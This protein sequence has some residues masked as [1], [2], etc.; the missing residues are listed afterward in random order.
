MKR[1]ATAIIAVLVIVPLLLYAQ[2]ALDTTKVPTPNNTS[3]PGV[4]QNGIARPMIGM[5]TS[6][7]VSIDAAARGAIFGGALTVTGNQT[8]TGT[9]TVTGAQTF[10]GAATFDGT[11]DFNG[12]VTLD[13]N[14]TLG[15]A[16]TDTVTLTGTLNASNSINAAQGTQAASANNLDLAETTGNVFEITGTTQINQL[17]TTGWQNGSTVSLLFADAVTI[18]HNQ[19]PTGLTARFVTGSAGSI[20]TVAN[21]VWTFVLTTSASV[22]AWRV[23]AHR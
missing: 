5:D 22:R 13:A 4:D 7:R 14:T 2:T 15:N 19:T 1:L 3:F 21:E 11:A 9:Q 17:N 16:A 20:V 8:V 12:N 18:A 6:G 23:L 10:T